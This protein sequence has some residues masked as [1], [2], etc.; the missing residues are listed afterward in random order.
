MDKSLSKKLDELLKNKKTLQKGQFLVVTKD[1]AD[2]IK[3]GLAKHGSHDQRTHSPTGRAARVRG[4]SGDSSD[5][6]SLRSSLENDASNLMFREA[7]TSDS[8]R[9]WYYP[10]LPKSYKPSKEAKQLI[11]DGVSQNK[12]STEILEEAKRRAARTHKVSKGLA[13]HGTHNQKDHAAGVSR[14][15]HI[16]RP[17]Q[18]KPTWELKNMKRALSS[19]PLLNTEDDERRLKAVEDELRSRT[20]RKVAKLTIRQAKELHGRVRAGFGGRKVKP[21]AI[22]SVRLG[23]T[24]VS[25]GVVKRGSVKP[26]GN[27]IRKHPTKLMKH[28]GHAD[29]SVHGRRKVYAGAAAAGAAGSL[30]S[31]GIG[32]AVA[33][34]VRG[35]GAAAAASRAISGLV[36]RA[37]RLNPVTA[38]KFKRAKGKAIRAI[39]RHK[40]KLEGSWPPPQ[41]QG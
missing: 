3:K 13:K 1:E 9:V 5:E 11:S 25:G 33:P 38:K 23:R 30:A 35:L 26:K 27:K 14:R 37:E 21:T 6:A 4:R 28:P 22:P 19:L 12:S 41:E 39:R 34:A 16:G 10:K 17:Y 31:R 32:R 8:F 24:T 40:A 18:R 7:T 29:Q 2:T 36:S 20:S 15:A